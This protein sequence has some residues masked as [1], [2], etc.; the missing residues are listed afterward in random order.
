MA[1]I[2]NLLSNKS[3][4]VKSLSNYQHL[5]ETK[6]YAFLAAY[7]LGA[8]QKVLEREFYE[9]Y[10]YS[11][12]TENCKEVPNAEIVRLY[13][14]IRIAIISKYDYMKDI[15]SFDDCSYE[16]VMK[17]LT[18]LKELGVDLQQVLRKTLSMADV[19]NHITKEVKFLVPKVLEDFGVPYPELAQELFYYYDVTPKTATKLAKT[20]SVSWNKF[21]HGVPIIKG[22]KLNQGLYTL[23]NSDYDFYRTL[24]ALTGFSKEDIK[25]T[26]LDW[27]KFSKRAVVPRVPITQQATLYVD[28]DNINFYHFLALLDGLEKAKPKNIRHKIKLFIDESANPIW[29]SIEGIIPTTSDFEY[30]PVKR[31]KDNKSVVDIVI[32]HTITKDSIKQA[33]SNIKRCIVSSDSDFFGLMDYG[34]DLFVFYDSTCTSKEYLH[35]LTMKNQMSFDTKQLL[36]SETNVGY[37]YNLITYYTLRQLARTAPLDWSK[38]EVINKIKASLTEDFYL[39]D[40]LLDDE[41]SNLVCKIIQNLEIKKDGFIV[42]LEQDGTTVSFDLQDEENEFQTCNQSK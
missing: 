42:K 8:E 21:P 6:S 13:N 40:S 10:I 28:C 41:L 30:I 14:H 25:L 32:S 19:L 38:P 27:S 17:D 26:S 20:L 1:T 18:D 2:E 33:N 35:Y 16:K 29:R 7:L 24:F 23:F 4:A 15:K 34:I 39:E 5:M 12:S 11:G 9:D 31:I 22:L 36:I 37:R 3:N